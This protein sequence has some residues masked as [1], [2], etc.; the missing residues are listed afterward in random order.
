MAAENI[1]KRIDSKWR[2]KRRP[3]LHYPPTATFRLHSTMTSSQM[4]KT[5]TSLGLHITCKTLGSNGVGGRG[6]P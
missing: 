5:S 4:L 2:P 6:E 1:I 3:T